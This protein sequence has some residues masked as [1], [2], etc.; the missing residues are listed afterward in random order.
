MKIATGPVDHW[1]GIRDIIRIY[2]YKRKCEKAKTEEERK[3]V[4]AGREG[5]RKQGP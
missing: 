1:D 5:V 4:R 3:R 2:K